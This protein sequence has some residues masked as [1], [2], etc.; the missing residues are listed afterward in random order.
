MRI[1]LCD[2][3]HRATLYGSLPM[4][5]PAKIGYRQGVRRTASFRVFVLA[6]LLAASQLVF[7]THVSS[8]IDF[9]A[10]HCE[11]CVCQVQTLAGPLPAAAPVDI[12]RPIT[13]LAPA[14]EIPF[15]S[16]S[17]EPGYQSRAPPSS[18]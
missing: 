10:G 5:Y 13:L 4:D 17:L 16:R 3:R 18:S 2:G 6:G 15:P 9:K 7:A 14:V 12:E 11:W 1:C 8:H